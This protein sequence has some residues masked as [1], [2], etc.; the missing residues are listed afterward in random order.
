[1]LVVC[2][3]VQGLIFPAALGRCMGLDQASLWL[4]VGAP[5]QRLVCDLA[6]CGIT[7]MRSST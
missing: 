3:R 1:M 2:S 7:I 5:A 4:C 6:P